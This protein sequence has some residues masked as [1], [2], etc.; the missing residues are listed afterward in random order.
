MLQDLG[1]DQL[2]PGPRVLDRATVVG[3]PKLIGHVGHPGVLV[4]NQVAC[5]TVGSTRGPVGG[6]GPIG[7]LGHGGGGIRVFLNLGQGIHFSVIKGLKVST[8]GS[9]GAR[10]SGSGGLRR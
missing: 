9:F 3:V 1:I 2:V 5:C 4:N 7:A 10:E 6:Q 8:R